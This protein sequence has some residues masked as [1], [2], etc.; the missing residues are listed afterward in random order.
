MKKIAL[1]G[2]NG[3]GKF[4][5]VDDEDFEELNKYKWYCDA[6][7]YARRD[8]WISKK[9]NK[10]VLMH[11]YLLNVEKGY[12]VDH[13]NTIRLDNQKSNLR[14]AT[15]QQNRRNK[16]VQKNSKTQLKGVTLFQNGKFRAYI[17]INSKQIHLG[18]FIES[19]DAAHAYNEAAINHHGE[20]ANINK[21]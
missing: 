1:G 4:A 5:L 10:P 15:L 16:T 19:I 6:H 18:Y 9:G 17:N 14:K 12:Q 7:G 20:F 3:E 8:I 21:L 2:K 11:K 13:K